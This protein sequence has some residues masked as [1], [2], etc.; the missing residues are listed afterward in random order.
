MAGAGR[1]FLLGAGWGS[2]LRCAAPQ[3]WIVDCA[4]MFHVELKEGK[5]GANIRNLTGYKILPDAWP[6]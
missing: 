2:A 5:I 4:A 6:L 3:R 1:P